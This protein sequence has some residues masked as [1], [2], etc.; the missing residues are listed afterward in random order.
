MCKFMIKSLEPLHWHMEAYLS[1]FLI[2]FTTEHGFFWFRH[3]HIQLYKYARTHAHTH[4]RTLT[5]RKHTQ[6]FSGLSRQFSEW[7]AKLKLMS[8]FGVIKNTSPSSA[9]LA[10]CLTLHEV[11]M[12][13]VYKGTYSGIQV[14]LLTMC[15]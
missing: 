5:S 2:S 3:M 13:F 1:L 4:V 15:G 9:S 8:F 7:A 11:N 10:W 12:D 14:I 6:D